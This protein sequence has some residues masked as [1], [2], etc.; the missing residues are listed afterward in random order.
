M[1][2]WI[3]RFLARHRRHWLV[4]KIGRNLL[5]Y[6]QGFDNQD[7][8]HSSNGE[9]FVLRTLAQ[10]HPAAVIMDV[11][12]NRG[13]WAKMAVGAV[14]GGSVHALEVIPAT[15]AKLL[16]TCAQLPNVTPYNLGLGEV[17]GR[18]E[19]SVA[20]GRDELASGL[21]GVHGDFHKFD[22]YTV[23]CPMLT[24]DAFCERHALPR[25]DFL[26]LDVEGLEPMVLRGFTRMLGENRIGAVQFEYGQ[27]NL[28]ARF[29]LG[30]FHEFFGRYG[31]K[32]G[33]IYP[34]HVDF[35]DYH[36]TQ[37]NLTGPNFLAVSAAEPE[38]LRRWTA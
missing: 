35:R 6:Y 33:K 16:E 24:G 19:F 17:S 29:F 31:M 1:R 34:N 38:L 28:K 21:A 5:Y 25:I 3:R 15:Y 2:D 4:N 32:V 37:D 27:L 12:A 36:F 22:F 10:V 30:D 8:D 23:D 26:K 14:P 18:L 13:D 7:Y 20:K 11:G 9:E